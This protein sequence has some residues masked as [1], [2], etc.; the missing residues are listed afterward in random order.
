MCV[1]LS[2]FAVMKKKLC[3]WEIIKRKSRL[4]P[5]QNK[6][7]IKEAAEARENYFF[8]AVRK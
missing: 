8:C 5:P 6:K 4:W 7:K 2:H 3:D 1:A